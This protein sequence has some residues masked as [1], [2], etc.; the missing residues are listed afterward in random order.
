MVRTDLLL[1]KKRQE[2]RDVEREYKNALMGGGK[3][4]GVGYDTPLPPLTPIEPIQL[5]PAAGKPAPCDATGARKYKSLVNQGNL[6]VMEIEKA[7]SPTSWAPSRSPGGRRD[8]GSSFDDGRSFGGSTITSMFSKAGLSPTSR[9]S[10]GAPRSPSTGSLPPAA[11]P[12][13]SMRSSP[14]KGARPK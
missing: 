6:D 7:Y 1:H 13:R 2:V 4:S 8:D 14:T 12:T 3:Q 5:D 9:A 11:S 10:P